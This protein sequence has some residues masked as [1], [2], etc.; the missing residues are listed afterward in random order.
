MLW[1]VVS[2]DLKQPTKLFQ[3]SS[4]SMMVSTRVVMV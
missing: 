2:G 3:Y 4:A 1:S